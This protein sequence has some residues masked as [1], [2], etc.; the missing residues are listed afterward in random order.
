MVLSSASPAAP[1][2][3]RKLSSAL[4]APNQPVIRWRFWLQPNTQGMARRSARLAAP[5][6]RAG[7]EPILSR[8]SSSTGLAAW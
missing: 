3:S 2:T 1:R 7:R 4:P 8:T 6:R 5:K